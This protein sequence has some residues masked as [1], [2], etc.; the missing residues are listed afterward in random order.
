ME[1]GTLISHNLSTH[2]VEY[3]E[4]KCGFSDGCTCYVFC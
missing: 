2:N 4:L 3:A 1:V